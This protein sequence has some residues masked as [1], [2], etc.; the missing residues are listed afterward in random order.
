MVFGYWFD[1]DNFGPFMR[2]HR[3]KNQ[4]IEWNNGEEKK[5]Y[6]YRRNYYGFRG[7]DIEPS[8][9]QAVIFGGSVIDERYKPDEYTITEFL[10]KK[11][12][13]NNT[14]IK[15]TNGA[16]EGKSTIGLIYS[17][18][19]WL[20]K[21]KGLSPQ[22]LLFYIGLND[23]QHTAE[24]NFY[25]E[26]GHDG[27]TLNPERIQVFFDT[28]KSRSYLYD[29][30]RIFKFKYLP[31]KGF[32]KYDGKTT[33]EY[34]KKFNFISYKFAKNNYNLEN[35]EKKYKIEIKNY[36]ARV[37]K[38]IELSEK[39]NST[40]IFITNIASFGH[41]EKLF[42]L[43]NSLIKNCKIKKISCIDLAKKIDGKI[44]YWYDGAHTSKKGSEYIS[45]LIYED[46]KN[47][48]K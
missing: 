27:H 44:E 35:L 10:N 34:K 2:E 36:I 3:M 9:I 21:M 42:A 17:F 20:F 26:A 39:L 16:I 24:K 15:I 7:E 38:L 45:N 23:S 37:E 32:V 12:K 30:I 48:I 13:E 6:F 33:S 31:R 47:L 40:P 41:T 46:L 5:I 8:K 14:N 25:K 19:K 22:Y 4:R 18:E 1:E 11:L 43:N 29:S 28:I